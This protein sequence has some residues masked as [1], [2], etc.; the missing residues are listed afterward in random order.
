MAKNLPKI[1]M[2]LALLAVSQNIKEVSSPELNKLGNIKYIER[3]E[4]NLT[5]NKENQE[6]IYETIISLERKKEFILMRMQEENIGDS[7]RKDYLKKL[8]ETNRELTEYYS[9]IE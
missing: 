1:L 7:I 5:K 4:E 8:G 3:I 6:K 9:Q 2:S